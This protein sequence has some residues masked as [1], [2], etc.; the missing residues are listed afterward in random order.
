MYHCYTSQVA[1]SYIIWDMRIHTF[2]HHSPSTQ[3]YILLHRKISFRFRVRGPFSSTSRVR[4]RP[5]ATTACSQTWRWICPAAQASEWPCPSAT[6]TLTTHLMTCSPATWLGSFPTSIIIQLIGSTRSSRVITSNFCLFLLRVLLHIYTRSAYVMSLYILFPLPIQTKACT[7]P[8]C[9]TRTTTSGCCCC[10]ALKRSWR[11]ATCRQ[12]SCLGAQ[13]RSSRPS[14]PISGTN[15]PG[16]A[17]PS[18]MCSLCARTTA[19]RLLVDWA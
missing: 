15:W 4:R 11:R 16:T 7:T 10:T 19:T 9:W 5:S 13:S 3:I 2:L 18:S 1:D 12:S 6:V 14:C 8:T 17:Y